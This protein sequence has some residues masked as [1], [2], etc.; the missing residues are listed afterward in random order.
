MARKAQ[1][2]RTYPVSIN[3]LAGRMR[4]IESA[5]IGMS[6][7]A[8][9]Q[10]ATGTEFRVQHE[11]IKKSHGEKVTVT[12]TKIDR[13]TTVR[14]L[15]QVAVPTQLNDGGANQKNVDL[16]FEFLELGLGS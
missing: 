6:L 13:G 1:G 11:G 15:S 8:E 3:I 14:I 16:L 10:T 5:R 9:N 4:E 12:M 2:E 7:K